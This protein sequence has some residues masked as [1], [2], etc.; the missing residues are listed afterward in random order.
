[1]PLT[2]DENF[3]A[4]R[5]TFDPVKAMRSGAYFRIQRRGFAFEVRGLL[6]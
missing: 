1:M 5:S 2:T 3:P 6:A 4:P